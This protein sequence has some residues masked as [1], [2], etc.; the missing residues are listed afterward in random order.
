MACGKLFANLIL[1]N[2]SKLGAIMTI[3]VLGFFFGVGLRFN[4][5]KYDIRLYGVIFDSTKDNTLAIQN[6]IDSCSTNGGG[7]VFI[8]QFV[9]LIDSLTKLPNVE[10]KGEGFGSVLKEN[11]A[12]TGGMIQ[13]INTNIYNFRGLQQGHAGI[14][15]L[16]LAGRTLAAIGIHE[17][18]TYW[19]EDR[20]I[21][22]DSC[23]SEA[24]WYKGCLSM[25]LRNWVINDGPNG[26]ICDSITIVP[27]LVAPNLL[28]MEAIHAYRNTNW[29][30]QV[31]NSQGAIHFEDC[32]VTQC[33]TI[34]NPNT[35]AWRIYG[36]AAAGTG[37]TWV[38][39]WSEVCLG[40]IAYIDHPLGTNESYDF[41]GSQWEF[42]GSASYGIREVSTVAGVKI[43]MQGMRVTSDSVDVSVDGNGF[44]SMEGA[45]YSVF[46]PSGQDYQ[47]V[48]DNANRI[49][50][51]AEWSNS[52]AMFV[53]ALKNGA[54]SGATSSVDAN[55]EMMGFNFTL[56]TGTGCTANDT[57]AII[58]YPIAMFPNGAHFV[59]SP[60][61]ANAAALSG[62]AQV[63]VKQGGTFFYPYIYS[64]ATAL[65][66]STTYIWC[67]KPDG[68]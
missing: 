7:T 3:S 6:A 25:T 29:G 31:L 19:G 55:S 65:D 60:V 32:D 35:G 30:I 62:S 56:N 4:T 20:D 12:T 24:A 8:P 39:C 41:I 11:V 28:R 61:N 40:T 13:E 22:I 5:Y 14:S 38:N 49:L 47:Y 1:S 67:I 46:N 54:G 64:P 15:G 44:V 10:L 23:T 34:H 52:G 50:G 68:K 16:F 37:A 57:V 26:I 43:N 9:W 45:S 53:S 2:M 51:P 27:G 48:R 36:E 21:R 17:Q 18:F 42:N 63:Y 33:G 66:P 58:G 59:M